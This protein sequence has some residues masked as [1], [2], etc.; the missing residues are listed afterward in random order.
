MVQ[1][2]QRKV[3]SSGSRVQNSGFRVW[4]SGSGPGVGG[5]GTAPCLFSVFFLWGQGGSRRGAGG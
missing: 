3:W 2:Q 1:G 5:R 4:D